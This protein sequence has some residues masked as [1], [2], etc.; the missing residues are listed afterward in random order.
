MSALSPDDLLTA[1]LGFDLGGAILLAKGL[2]ASPRDIGRRAT[3][4][5]DFSAAEAVSLARDRIDAIAGLTSLAFGFILQALVSAL[6]VLGLSP[7]SRGAEQAAVAGASAIAAL[8]VAVGLWWAVRRR[9]LLRLLVKIAHFENAG[10]RKLDRPSAR[11]LVFFGQELEIDL[12]AR[13]ILP[14]GYRLYAER[15]FGVS[16]TAEEDELDREW[17]TLVDKFERRKPC[18]AAS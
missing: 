6:L 17:P 7:G 18:D 16:R 11:R 5:Y 12:T 1:G 10:S 13:E 9:F 3:S 15:V 14:G 8:G 4:F 2:L